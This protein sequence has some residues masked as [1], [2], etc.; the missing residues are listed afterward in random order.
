M[1]YF[2]ISESELN[3]LPEEVKS[4][5]SPYT[6]EDTEGLKNK[7]N[8]LL[9]EKK[10]VEAA[11]A[12][13]LAKMAVMEADMKKGKLPQ[14]DSKLKDALEQLSAAKEHASKLEKNISDA[15]ID[16]EAQKIGASLAPSDARRAALIA[17]EAKSRLQLEGDNITVLSKDGKPTISTLKELTSEFKTE[18]DFLVDG[19]KAS[20][21]GASGGSGRAAKAP[22]KTITRSEFDAMDPH[23]RSIAIK[24]G[25]TP[26]DD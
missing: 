24:D 4:K 9:S 6:P 15:K 18:Y 21:G 26:I 7:A 2:E 13:A 19:S 16:S 10:A 23:E 14:D 22:S 25:V 8:Q 11:K 12:E 5:L 17:K 3:N 20:G 1:P